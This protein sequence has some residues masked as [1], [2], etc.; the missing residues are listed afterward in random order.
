[1]PLFVHLAPE[2]Y[3]KRILR[4]G[5]SPTKLKHVADGGDRF[6]W[7]FP[8][9]ESHTLTHQWTRELK[10]RGARTMVAITF[11]I[12]AGEPVFAQRYNEPLCAMTAGEAVALI[13]ALDDPR[14]A[15]VIIPRR[16]LP[17]E[18]VRAKTLRQHFGWRYFPAV[19]T[20]DRRPCD[21]PYCMPRGEVKAKRY[22]DRVPLLA[23]RWDE[24]R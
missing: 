19:K 5:I 16:I 2:P 8:V 15:E 11:R 7:A 21:C 6:V 17:G 24:R 3:Q 22:R 12:E 13:R 23:R 20:A 9:L 4:N 14:G 18:I 10:R 1:M